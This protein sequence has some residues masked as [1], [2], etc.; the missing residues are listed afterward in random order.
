MRPLFQSSFTDKAPA[1]ISNAHLITH[2]LHAKLTRLLL[3][4]Y[5]SNSACHIIDIRNIAAR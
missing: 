3:P 5:D 1:Q 4:V 2:I